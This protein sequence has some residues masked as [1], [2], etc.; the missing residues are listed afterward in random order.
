MAKNKELYANNPTYSRPLPKNLA[1]KTS[2][3]AKALFGL[4][5]S[6]EEEKGSTELADFM[7]CKSALQ[8]DVKHATSISMGQAKPEDFAQITVV[9]C[10]QGL[11]GAPYKFVKLKP[12]SADRVVLFQQFVRWLTQCQVFGKLETLKK[13]APVIMKHDVVECHKIFQQI[14]DAIGSQRTSKRRPKP[15]SKHRHS[16]PAPANY[17]LDNRGTQSSPVKRKRS[18]DVI[19]ISDDEPPPKNRNKVNPSDEDEVIFVDT[20]P[21]PRRSTKGKERAVESDV[22]SSPR[23]KGIVYISSEDEGEA[24]L[25]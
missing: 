2:D 6:L 16:S 9:R 5:L 19:E 14:E 11:C 7:K 3:M 12:T 1:S 10:G 22:P 8:G 4:R 13:I 17:H 23:I 18:W 15:R 25:P 24:A 20:I 21:I